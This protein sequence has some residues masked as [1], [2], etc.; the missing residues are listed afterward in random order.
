MII[1]YLKIALRNLIRLKGFT[2][3]NIIG[4]SIGIAASILIVQ[5][6]RT[7]VSV[8]KHHVGLEDLYRVNTAFSVGGKETETATSPSPLAWTLVHDFPEVD[9]AARLIKAPGVNQFLIKHEEKSFFE[10]KTYFVDSTFFDVLTYQFVEGDAKHMIKN[11]LEVAVS[12]SV[13][14]KLFGQNLAVGQTIEI[15]SQWGSDQYQITGVFDQGGHPSH[16]DGEIYINMRSGAIGQ[17]FYD[18]NEWAG[19]NL[20]LTYIK[21]N[22]QASA[23][24]LEAKFPDLVESKAGDRLR[25]LGFSKRHFLEPVMD[26]YL[27]SNVSFQVG[28]QG[29]QTMVYILGII[30]LFVLVIACINFMNLATAKATLR[31]KEV[32]VRKVVGASRKVLS[33][34]FMTE[35]ILYTLLALGGSFL[36]AF[37]ILPWFNHLAGRT[38]QLNIFEDTS[39]LWWTLGILLF[40]SLLAGSYPSLY[41]S[42]FSPVHILR[43]TLGKGMTARNVRKVLVVTQFI[44][45]VALIQGIFIIQ[46][47]LDFVRNKNLGFNAEEKIV[48]P[49]NTTSSASKYQLLK[50]ELS[51]DPSILFVGGSSTIPGITNPNDGLY[52]GEGQDPS[53]NVHANVNWVDPD[54]LALMGFDLDKGRMFTQDRIADTVQSTIITKSMVAKLGYNKENVIGKNLYWTWDGETNSHQI[55]G[56]IDDYHANSL[57]SEVG[58]QIF[59]WSSTYDPAYMVASIE[60]RQINQLIGKIESTW[61]KHVE[62]DPFEFYF[63]DDRLQKAYETDQRMGSLIFAFTL[64]AIIISCLGLFGLAAF[65]AETRRR[66]I[67]I[68]K[69]LGASTQGIVSLLSREFLILVILAILIATPIAWYFMGQW[70]NNFHYHISLSWVTFIIAGLIALFI[71]LLTVGVQG[72]RAA[73]SHPVLAIKSE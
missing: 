47:Q 67:G 37:S 15:S 3:L 45:S 71:A 35:T 42:S 64:L 16:I 11:P 44:I 18:L 57:H 50:N 65:A 61:Q 13:A 70:L 14:T 19:N 48:I 36:I 59:F 69:V 27:K 53:N 60:T 40:T 9:Q 1:N 39:L 5:F 43:G 52:Y 68:R 62:T 21:L 56:V 26:I 66:E 20:Y 4:L 63:L 54:Y 58:N 22:P 49:L 6:L 41:L 51:A 72:L 34:Q 32:A 7:E 12:K 55:I 31:T 8:D 10:S 23:V 17:T 28:P 29:N 30:A 33:S 25:T 2:A 38:I 46:H 24:G 73:S